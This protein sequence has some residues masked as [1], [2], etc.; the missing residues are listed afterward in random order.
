[1]ASADQQGGRLLS[2][3]QSL[4]VLSLDALL[5]NG[6]FGT[7]DLGALKGKWT[8]LFFYPLDFTFV[9]PTEI[10]AFDALNSEFQKNNT[11][12]LGV[13]VDSKFTHRA[14]TQHELGELS[15]PLLSDLSHQLSK[16]CGVL[17]P[18]GYALRATFIVNP[19]G[20][21]QSVT[22]NA[23]PIGRS[24]DETLRLVQAMQEV[25]ANGGVAP[26]SWKP[27]QSLLQPK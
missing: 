14:W 13:S 19:E 18:N 21:V 12:L 23:A 9:C 4:P 6:E 10:K 11:V 22:I 20:I 7:V 16:E 2:A 3:G 24:P 5:P 15:F 17:D 1:M 8:V 27:G 25:A 26:C